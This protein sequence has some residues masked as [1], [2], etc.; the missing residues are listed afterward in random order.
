MRRAGLMVIWASTELRH[1]VSEHYT[2]D[3]PPGLRSI[4]VARRSI[5]ALCDGI[6]TSFARK[7]AGKR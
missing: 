3:P 7:S 4:T 5:E 2:S 6:V 1:A